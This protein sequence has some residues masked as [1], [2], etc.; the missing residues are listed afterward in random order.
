LNLNTW[1]IAFGLNRHNTFVWPR[2]VRPEDFHSRLLPFYLD[3][4]AFDKEVMSWNGVKCNPH[5]SWYALPLATRAPEEK[6]A[7]RRSRAKF[8][9]NRKEAE[10][11][12]VIRLRRRRG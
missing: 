6:G 10:G 3:E 2:H 9:P 5:K 4:E 8:W 12:N 1:N 11:P 7:G